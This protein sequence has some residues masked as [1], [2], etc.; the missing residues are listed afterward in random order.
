MRGLLTS[1]STL[2]HRFSA[3]GI[4]PEPNSK[5]WEAFFSYERRLLNLASKDPG[6]IQEAAGSS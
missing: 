2:R 1:H 6:L 3:A 5:E 4:E